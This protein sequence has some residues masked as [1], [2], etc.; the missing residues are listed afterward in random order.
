MPLDWGSIVPLWFLGH[1]RHLPGYGNVLADDPPED[2]GPPVVVVSPSRSLP[3]GSNVEFGAAVA[4]AAARDAKR[5]AF[6]ASCDWA[7]AHPGG[8]AEFSEAAAEVD[9]TVV[10]AIEQ[11]A[12]ESLISLDEE[13]VESSAIDGL[14]QLLMLA[15]AL[16]DGAATP[17]VLSY[18]APSAYAT[19]MIVAAFP[20]NEP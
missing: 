20:V 15:G 1:G 13:L 2:S 14:W 10:R 17:E 12:L 8:R 4:A 9:A 3:R 5:V 16:R 11:N 18:E 6:I 7:H 19:G